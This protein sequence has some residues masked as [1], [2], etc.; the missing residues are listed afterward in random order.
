MRISL[1]IVSSVKG[2]EHERG[3]GGIRVAVFAPRLL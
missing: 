2:D 3:H 1:I